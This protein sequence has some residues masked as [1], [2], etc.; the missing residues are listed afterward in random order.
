[1]FGKY[2]R[3]QYDELF[4]KKSEGKFTKGKGE[5]G[6][7]GK[8]E[9]KP[10]T[11]KVCVKHETGSSSDGRSGRRRQSVTLTRPRRTSGDRSHRTRLVIT[12]KETARLCS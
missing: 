9:K 10:S 1:M 3:N 11:F 7:K 5:K 6:K 2:V 12:E 8:K 4:P